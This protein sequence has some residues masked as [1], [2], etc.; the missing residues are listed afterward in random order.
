MPIKLLWQTAILCLFTWGGAQITARW[1]LPIPG[2]VIGMVLLFIFLCLGVVKL[3]HIEEAVNLLLKHMLFFFIPMV[4]GLIN[5]GTLLYKSGLA[6]ATSIV[7]SVVVALAMTGVVVQKFGT[8]RKYL[9]TEIKMAIQ[10]MGIDSFQINTFTEDI[11]GGGVKV[12]SK[13]LL[14]IGTKVNCIISGSRLGI[15]E[16]TG[17]VVRNEERGQ[18]FRLAIN[19]TEMSEQDRTKLIA[20]T[21]RMGE[22][23]SLDTTDTN[24]GFLQPSM[25]KH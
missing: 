1:Q 2:S 11:S 6:L 14:E 7:V 20:F 9:R 25:E 21:C 4:V 3:Q 24:Q 10:I 12:I 19:F 16:A 5:S 17:E 23:I 15:I 8:G 13:Q 22:H 18:D